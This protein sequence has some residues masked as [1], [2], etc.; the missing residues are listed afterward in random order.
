MTWLKTSDDFPMECAQVRLSDAAF[1][2]HVEGL[3]WV[4]AKETGGYVSARALKRFAETEN[5]DAAVDELVAV[6]FWRRV[7]GGWQIVHHMEHQPTPE[8]LTAQRAN[9]AAK[10][11][12]HR[13]RRMGQS[14][15]PEEARNPA[16]NPVTPRVTS[17]R[18][19]T[20]RDWGTTSQTSAKTKGHSSAHSSNGSQEKCATGCGWPVKAAGAQFCVDH[21][22]E[23]LP[24]QPP[25]LR[26]IAVEEEGS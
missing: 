4:M 15:L 2:T 20:G 17:G 16:T 1:R 5:W 24:S 7:D 23:D 22:V 10:Q 18:D 19:G 11:A 8:Q 26:L 25:S 13:A 14:T 21:G 12:R 6:G 9:N 3:S